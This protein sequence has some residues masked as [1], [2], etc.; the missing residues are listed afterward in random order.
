VATFWYF[1]HFL[2]ILPWLN[3]VER[4]DAL[5]TSIAEPVLKG[6]G[7]LAV[8]AATAKPMEKA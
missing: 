5:P 2:V 6:G 8:G 7:G 4:P 1:F 3:F